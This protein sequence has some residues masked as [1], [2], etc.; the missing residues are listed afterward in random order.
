MTTEHDDVSFVGLL[1]HRRSRPVTVMRHPNYT[2]Y[3]N[4]SMQI[5]HRHEDGH[6]VIVDA[7]PQRKTRCR[8]R[9]SYLTRE[10]RR[11]GIDMERVNS[12]QREN[13]SI[14]D[15]PA[16]PTEAAFAHES[17]HSSFP[18]AG[19]SV[20]YAPAAL[21]HEQGGND[22]NGENDDGGAGRTRLFS[23][24]RAVTTTDTVA[25]YPD[26]RTAWYNVFHRTH[27][28]PDARRLSESA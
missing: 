26:L 13:E 11:A 8:I 6:C 27:D 19:A 9:P 3:S 7:Y 4:G 17:A 24:R 25:V 2:E 23:R 12:V 15:A 22:D 1:R 10:I 14:D 5:L 28:T 18:A 16:T 21:E 20:H